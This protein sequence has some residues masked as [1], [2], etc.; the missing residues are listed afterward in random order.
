MPRIPTLTAKKVVKILKQNGFQ[1]DRSTGSHFVFYNPSTRK[2]ITV[3]VHSKDL[4]RGTM[5]S[6]LRQAGLSKKKND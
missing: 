4:P 1:L 3:P 2:C 6:I 5:L